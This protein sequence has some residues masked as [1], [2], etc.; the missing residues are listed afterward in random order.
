MS[1]HPA[2]NDNSGCATG[3]N[4]GGRFDERQ[5][6]VSNSTTFSISTPLNNIDHI[7]RM[8]MSM[9][10]SMISQTLGNNGNRRLGAR[11]VEI[12]R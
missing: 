3:Q 7:M 1:Q 8:I 4:Q 2:A 12:I 6:S 5:I 9:K 10:N 11:S